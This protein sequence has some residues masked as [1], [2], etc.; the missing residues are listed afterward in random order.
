MRIEAL[1]VRNYKVLRN[2]VMKDIPP[3]CVV[4]GA[5]GTGKT[6]LFDVFGFLK[7]CLTSNVTRA[8][9]ARGGFKEVCSRESDDPCIRFEIQFRMLIGGK[10]RLVTYILELK[11]ARG[12]P[13]IER[14]VLPMAICSVAIHS[15]AV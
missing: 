14:E 1:T 6:T 2:L 4:V 10:D 12:K 11:D 9:M 7:D 15:S 8:L 3:L 13:Y 5:N